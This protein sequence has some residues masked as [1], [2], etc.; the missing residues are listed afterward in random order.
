MR[1]TGRQTARQKGT[2]R[3]KQRR[4]YRWTEK[5]TD[6]GSGRGAWAEKEKDG[7]CNSRKRQDGSTRLQK[8]IQFTT[9][10]DKFL[11]GK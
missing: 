7:F 9:Q 10:C 2:E 8:T 6:A 1:Q 5:L 11:M 4:I 3:Q